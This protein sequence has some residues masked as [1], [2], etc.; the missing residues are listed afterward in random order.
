MYQAEGQEAQRSG[1]RKPHG[2]GEMGRVHLDRW[3]VRKY[4]GHM[5]QCVNHTS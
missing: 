5:V 2:F 3:E 4:I 1:S